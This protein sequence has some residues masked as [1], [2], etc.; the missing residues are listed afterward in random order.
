[1]HP[2]T[3]K[4]LSHVE[5]AEAAFASLESGFD[6]VGLNALRT[7]VSRYPDTGK[8]GA[9]EVAASLFMLLERLISDKRMDR[10]ALG[11]HLRAWRLLLS[12]EPSAE[13]AQLLIQG[14]KAIRD[15]S[16]Q[17]KAA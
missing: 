15:H 9:G 3:Q 1:M 4:R 8:P 17:A 10:E 7:A 2:A 12:T 16:T 6:P 11:V 13:A 14:L 5:A